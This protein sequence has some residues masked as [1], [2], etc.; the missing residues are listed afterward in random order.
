[1]ADNDLSLGRIV[2]GISRSRF[3]PTTCIFIVEDDPQ[4]GFD[5][6]D[7]HRSVCLVVSPYTKRHAVVSQFYNQGSVVHTIER[8]LGIAP[9]NRMYAL[10]PVMT[11]CF[12]PEPDL[13]PYAS[14]PNRV[15]LG[16]LNPDKESLRGDDRRFAEA[17][18]KLRLD[19]PDLADEDT[20]NRVLWHA[21]KGDRPYP[22]E[23]AGAHGRG[24]AKLG[25]EAAPSAPEK[26]DDD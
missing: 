24:L 1:V 3:W 5:H 8:I 18:E 9:A 12:A 4:D 21:A 2:E 25:L 23:W 14:A 22:A 17:S 13:T 19:K 16:E 7:G 11:A 15:P 10:A 6:V 26:D 20:L